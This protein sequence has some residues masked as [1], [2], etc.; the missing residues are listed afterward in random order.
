MKNV[1]VCS[2]STKDWGSVW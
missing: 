1:M 2:G